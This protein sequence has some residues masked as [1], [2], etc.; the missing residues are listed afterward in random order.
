MKKILYI[1]IPLMLA[2]AVTLGGCVNENNKEDTTDPAASMTET[3]NETGAAETESISGD[4]DT[5]GA[6]SVSDKTETTA[7][8]ITSEETAATVTENNPAETGGM[9]YNESENEDTAD[10]NSLFG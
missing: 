6:E 9:S 10:F 3:E 1:F 2:A 5:T 4:A 7:A 8:D